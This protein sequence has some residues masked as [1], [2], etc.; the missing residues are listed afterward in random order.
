MQNTLREFA[1]TVTRKQ[2]AHSKPKVLF[3]MYICNNFNL[4][5]FFLLT[6]PNIICIALGLHN[7][8]QQYNFII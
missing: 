2:K 3:S 7:F 5:R 8:T 6:A 4:S 1:L